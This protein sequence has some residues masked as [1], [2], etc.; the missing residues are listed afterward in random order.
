MDEA[1][2]TSTPCVAEGQVWEDDKGKAR[3]LAV[4]EGYV[5]LRR[6]GHIAR[7]P[8]PFIQ[9]VN[10]LLTGQHGWRQVKP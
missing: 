10:V 2:S 1:A 5:M 3:V 4:R 9:S 7:Q 8:N 6:R